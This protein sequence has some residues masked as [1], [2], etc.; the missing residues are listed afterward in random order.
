MPESLT[1]AL[2]GK[3]TFDALNM[4]FDESVKV[5]EHYT[6]TVP[7]NADSR[8][9][10]LSLTGPLNYLVILRSNRAGGLTMASGLFECSKS[11]VKDSMIDDAMFELVKMVAG[12]IR[13]AVA[14][15]H[16]LTEPV[17][18]A[19][20]DSLAGVRLLVGARLCLG[21]DEAQVDIMVSDPRPT[22]ET[23]ATASIVVAQSDDAAVAVVKSAVE[24]AGMQV[25]SQ[26]LDGVQALT[27]V[28]RLHPDV[29]CLDFNM[30]TMNGLDVFAAIRRESPNA[31]IFLVSATATADNVRSALKMRPNGIV[32]R[33]FD[34]QRLVNDISRALEQRRIKQSA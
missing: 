32:V 5:A 31:I 28:R 29:I 21:N 34:N 3:H 18:L 10:T 22:T 7:T 16:Q 11:D 6:A 12:Q 19:G 33:P 15:D 8:I 27:E 2:L 30:A 25:V 9:V 17:A 4:L 23:A 26:A 20:A 14:P 1:Q 13:T 24:L